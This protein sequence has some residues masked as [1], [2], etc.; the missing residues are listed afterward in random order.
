M[1]RVLILP[2]AAY[3]RWNTFVDSH[4]AGWLTHLS[5][6]SEILSSFLKGYQFFVLTITDETS[7]EIKAGLPLYLIKSPLSGKRSVGAPLATFFDPLI[8][9]PEELH[10]LIKAAQRVHRQFNGKYLTIKTF[11]TSEFFLHAGYKL[12]GD[13]VTHL[14]PLSDELD[15]IFKKFDRTCVRKNIRKAENSRLKIRIVKDQEGLKK[16]YRLYART[17]KRLGLPAIPFCFF[18]Q[19][20]KLFGPSGKAIYM[21]AEYGYTPVASLLIFLYKNR[22]SAEALGWETAFKSLRPVPFIY[23]EAIKLAHQQGCQYFDFGRTAKANTDLLFFKRNWGTEEIE[24]PEF[25]FPEG[26]DHFSRTEKL[27][28]YAGSI[29]QILPSSVYFLAS[30]MYYRFFLE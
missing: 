16:F 8:S 5:Q 25:I 17:R 22:C 29:C 3:A 15:N 2:P 21:L 9:S 14:L 28:N 18:S 6:W 4:P 24:L 19:I 27:K 11:Q 13:Y 23:W 30:H 7:G 12:K 1:S 20:F 10:L 26:K